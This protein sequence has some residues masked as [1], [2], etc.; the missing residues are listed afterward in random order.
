MLRYVCLSLVRRGSGTG[1]GRGGV[2]RWVDSL[3]WLL[4]FV[5][6]TALLQGSLEL[7]RSDFTLGNLGPSESTLSK[8]AGDLFVELLRSEER[9]GNRE[10]TG[11][12]HEVL[13]VPETVLVSVSKQDVKLLTFIAEES[14]PRGFVLRQLVSNLTT[15]KSRLVLTDFVV[16]TRGR[17]NR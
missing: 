6:A 15:V 11:P 2:S 8:S 3:T 1:V 7:V 10:T 12:R 4:G 14:R 5:V 13:G 16:E 9:L 17:S